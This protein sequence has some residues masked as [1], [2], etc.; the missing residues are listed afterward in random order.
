MSGMETE[1]EPIDPTD[2]VE[3][4]LQAETAPVNLTPAEIP[5]VAG[6]PPHV[7]EVEPVMTS[8]PVAGTESGLVTPTEK[9]KSEAHQ[10]PSD[11]SLGNTDKEPQTPVAQS[12]TQEM[13]IAP[14]LE[15]EPSAAAPEIEKEQGDAVPVVPEAPTGAR[16][17]TQP[18][19]LQLGSS[20]R[21][22][23]EKK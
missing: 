12:G 20:H 6:T 17:Q 14:D 21:L 18:T 4:T 11:A 2:S 1:T 16:S 8:S 10:D 3:E 9:P 15:D 23:A 19:P 7:S 5:V 13:E 22:R